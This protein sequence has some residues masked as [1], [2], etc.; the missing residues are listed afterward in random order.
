MQRNVLTLL[1]LL[2]VLAPLTGAVGGS[3]PAVAADHDPGTV[4]C[5][6]P[7]SATDATGTEVTVE[8]E[9]ERVVVLGPS[10]AQTMWEIG[11]ED[12]VVGMPV[13]QYTAYL[14][15][16]KSKE[17]V[18]NARGQPVNEKVVGLDPDLVLAPN[19]TNKDAVETLRDA[20]LTVYHFDA[21]TSFADVAAKT[22]LTGQLVGEFQAAAETTAEMEGTVDAI[23]DGVEGEDQPRVYYPM[24]GGYTA[25]SNTF[26]T[27]IITSAGGENIA[28]DAID[29]Y[30]VLSPEIVATQ[31]PEWLLMQEGFPVPQN[32]AVNGSTAVR[33]DQIVRVNPNYINQPAPRTTRVLRTVAETFHPEAYSQIDFENVETPEPAQCGAGGEAEDEEAANTFGGGFT[34]VVAVAAIA[35]VGLLARRRT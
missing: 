12:K 15:G 32:D 34:V 8:E 3:S 20:G 17:N 24:G 23:E 14:E 21:A 33:E 1:V 35:A 9:P 6:F 5:E 7:V 22:E 26:I 25:G 18:V 2:V 4:D 16:S 13:N 10:A 29:G 28:A 30:D 19:T 27:D 31:D 11:A